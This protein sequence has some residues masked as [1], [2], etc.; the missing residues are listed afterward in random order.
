MS[1]TRRLLVSRVEPQFRSRNDLT[2]PV[3]K[4]SIHAGVELQYSSAL[5]T[6]GGNRTTSFVLGNA[7]VHGNLLER[8]EVSL[9]VYNAFDRKYAYPGST[10]HFQDAIPQDGRT[11][12]AKATH[13]F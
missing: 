2:L 10:G 5:T 1:C 9:S 6:L 4:D 8:L 7:T 13:R 12:R 11:F 3:Y